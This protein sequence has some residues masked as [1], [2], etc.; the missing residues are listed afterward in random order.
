LL[1][2]RHLRVSYI[3]EEVLIP[4][5]G[6]SGAN[7][8]ELYIKYLHY[9]Q[10]DSVVRRIIDLFENTARLEYLFVRNS[11]ADVIPQ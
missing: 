7:I 11:A 6:V 10:K 5:V 2:L 1:N 8:K 9:Q 4:F 3:H